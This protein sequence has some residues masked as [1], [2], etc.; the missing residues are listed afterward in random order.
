M[1]R[2]ENLATTKTGLAHLEPHHSFHHQGPPAPCEMRPGAKV[3]VHRWVT[4]EWGPFRSP[5]GPSGVCAHPFVSFSAGKNGYFQKKATEPSEN[6]KEVRFRFNFCETFLVGRPRPL[7]LSPPPFR[8][9]CLVLVH[10][11]CTPCR[12]CMSGP[13]GRHT[14]PP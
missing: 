11:R 2:F 8:C 1:S 10:Y 6:E 9:R 4:V 12:F 14:T 7:S 3:G 5:P 13:R